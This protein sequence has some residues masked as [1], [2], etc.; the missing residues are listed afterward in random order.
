MTNDD[1]IIKSDVRI[2]IE[3]KI[4]DKI[5]VIVEHFDK[6]FG[7][8][9]VGEVKDG[10]IVINNIIFPKQEVSGASVD[11]DSKDLI[12]TRKQY[13]D[14]WG[15]ILGFWHSHLSMGTFWSGTRGNN[16][17]NGDEQH[18]HIISHA[19]EFSVFIVSSKHNG[20]FDHR[21][22]L[23]I[24]KPFK[25][26]LDNLTLYVIDDAKESIKEEVL[27]EV[28]SCIKEE[29][30]QIVEKVSN[31]SLNKYFNPNKRYGF[32]EDD[33]EIKFFFEKNFMTVTN[34]SYDKATIIINN[35]DMP[36]I[37]SGINNKGLWWVKLNAGNKQIAEALK[38]KI[39]E[40]LKKSEE[41]DYSGYD[42]NADFRG[43]W[44][45]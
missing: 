34:L 30:R 13:K 38:A 15:N 20:D 36:T 31:S 8:L 16:N 42:K 12:Q 43:F 24:T 39:E 41:F 17:C 21:V 22:R 19:K 28:K 5:E 9:L 33:L 32:Q 1:E 4:L 10:D 18:I 44:G 25:M 11:I 3:K 37:E 29:P 27:K 6:E 40:I 26:S 14:I 35:E 45:I 2:N 23:E 7:G